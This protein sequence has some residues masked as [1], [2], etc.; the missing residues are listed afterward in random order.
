MARGPLPDLMLTALQRD[1]RGRS[2]YVWKPPTSRTARAAVRMQEVHG[3]GHGLIAARNI[4]CG[5][6]VLSEA[7]LAR[8][9]VARAA[10]QE[11]KLES[12][13]EMAARLDAD[14]VNVIL[15]LSQAT[16]HGEQ[17]SL[18][19]TWMTNGLPINYEQSG[20][21][22][23]LFREAAVFA[24][25]CRLNHACRPNCHH[26]WNTRLGRATVHALRDIEAG[27]ELFIY[28]LPHRGMERAERQARLAEH[29]G[30]TCCCSACSLTADALTESDARR[31]AMGELAR[32]E[33]RG[34]GV[35]DLLSR[36]NLRQRFLELEELPKVWAWKPL[37]FALINASTQEFMAD[38][39][40]DITRSRLAGWTRQAE[41]CLRAALGDEH[42]GREVVGA[43]LDAVDGPGRHRRPEAEQ[44][45]FEVAVAALGGGS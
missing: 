40:D 26:E 10:T 19:G 22:A 27:E 2:R 29:F 25:V 32:P 8:W 36:L 42:P 7:P 24:T 44:R 38:P 6:R 3:S 11:Q 41:A 5:E 14:T 31:R 37:V 35:D 43:F 9:R 13:Q 21:S 45:F 23:D 33:E 17:Q 16:I 30:F 1:E 39:S 34:L 18:L 15:S 20:S 28:Y 4:S 12:F